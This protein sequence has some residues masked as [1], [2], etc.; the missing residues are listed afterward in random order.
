MRRRIRKTRIIRA[1]RWYDGKIRGHL[2][3]SR[4]PGGTPTHARRPCRQIERWVRAIALGQQVLLATGAA[5]GRDDK[6]FLRMTAIISCEMKVPNADQ[7]VI[8]QEKLCN[9]LLNVAHRRG[10]SKAKLLLA[11]GY[12]P[13]NW[14]QL[15]TDIRTQHL[16]AEVE[17]TMNTE[18]GTPYDIVAPPQGPSANS[19]MF[20]S[21]WQIDTGTQVPRLIT[22]YPE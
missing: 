22:M 11:M 15:E 6:K 19:V 12:R 1:P 18:Y 5:F 16:S 2:V 7:A 3:P 14:Q 8:A 17:S 21:V 9:Y 13:D 10:G 20:R 4:C